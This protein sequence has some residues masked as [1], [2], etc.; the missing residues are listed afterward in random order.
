MKFRDLFLCFSKK[1]KRAPSLDE[2]HML[3]D[4]SYQHL[5]QFQNSQ[6]PSAIRPVN[7]NSHMASNVPKC[8]YCSSNVRS[9]ASF[10]T[11]RNRTYRQLSTPSGPGRHTRQRNFRDLSAPRNDRTPRFGRGSR[12]GTSSNFSGGLKSPRR[13]QTLEE[14]S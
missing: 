6:Q 5:S 9:N 3:P 4:Q 11:D 7:T 1:K 12:R 2:R 13:L 10:M 14:Q 8:R